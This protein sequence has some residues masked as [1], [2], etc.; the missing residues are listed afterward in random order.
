MANWYAAC[1]LP[2]CETKIAEILTRKTIENYCPVV[3]SVKKINNDKKTICEALFTSWVFVRMNKNELYKLKSIDRIISL[4]Y[5][6]QNYAVIK[7]IEI[8]MIK[9]FLSEY[10]NIQLEKTEIK[11]NGMVKIGKESVIEKG[12]NG[13][14]IQYNKVRLTLPS[15]GYS[16]VATAECNNVSP[17]ITTRTPELANGIKS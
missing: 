16:I 5:W 13:V 2:G 9:R 14:S 11:I 8:E 12:N 15:L 17:V 3:K 6:Q 10:E 1:T 4:M 7:D